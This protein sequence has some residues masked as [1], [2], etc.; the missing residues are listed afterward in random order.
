MLRFYAR[1][2]ARLQNDLTASSVYKDRLGGA[3]IEPEDYFLNGLMLNR[4]GHPEMALEA[5]RKGTEIRPEFPEMLDH[6]ARLSVEL[7]LAEP[8]LETAR[9]LARQP[10]WE[11]GAGC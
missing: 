8:A 2:S 6:L 5:W 10:G 7:H 3:Q 11:C 4:A 1:A 9:R